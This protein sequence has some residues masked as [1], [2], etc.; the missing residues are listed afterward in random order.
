MFK[1]RPD[2]ENKEIGFFD[3]NSNDSDIN[4]LI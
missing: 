2:M 1:F 4:A 3:V